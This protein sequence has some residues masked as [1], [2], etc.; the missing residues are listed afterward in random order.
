MELN[1]ETKVTIQDYGWEVVTS[2]LVAKLNFVRNHNMFGTLDTKAQHFIKQQITRVEAS[3]AETEFSREHRKYLKGLHESV[4]L[5]ELED[6][7]VLA[8]LEDKR[9]TN[10]SNAT[11]DRP[12]Q[13]TKTEMQDFLGFGPTRK[14]LDVKGGKVEYV[15]AQRAPLT[16]LE[17]SG[18]DFVF[19]DK[20]TVKGR[21]LRVDAFGF[22]NGKQVVF[23]KAS[24]P[25]AP[26]LRP[27]KEKVVTVLPVGSEVLVLKMNSKSG[28]SIIPGIIKDHVGSDYYF[29]PE[30]KYRSSFTNLKSGKKNWVI[31]HVGFVFLSGSD[32]LARISTS[33]NE[34]LPF[35]DFKA[36]VKNN[37]EALAPS[38]KE[39]DAAK[40]DRKL[41]RMGAFK[42]ETP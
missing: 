38:L 37:T 30:K 32:L 31:V 26:I 16:F 25:D 14:A 5:R 24:L 8:E 41:L 12:A 35:K 22:A 1:R 20:S 4:L 33:Y 23:D 7:R 29:L 17:A 6:I 39:N 42:S 9:A 34:A 10:R 36:S 27:A 18:S 28:F 2:E 21:L 11:T 15:T 19:Y 40:K 3:G 13:P